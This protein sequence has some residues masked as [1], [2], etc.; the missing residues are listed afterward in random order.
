MPFIV[1][2]LLRCSSSGLF[3][4]NLFPAGALVILIRSGRLESNWRRISLRA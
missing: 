2:S 3:L 4:E 1:C